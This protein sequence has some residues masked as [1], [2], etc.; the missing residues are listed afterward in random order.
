APPA[1]GTPAGGRDR[2]GRA[3][4]RHR[5]AGGGLAAGVARTPV[6]PARRSCDEEGRGELHPHSGRTQG[7]GRRLRERTPGPQPGDRALPLPQPVTLVP[8]PL[9][10]GRASPST[11]LTGPP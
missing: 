9:G 11:S 2:A 6:L 3:R 5:P 4:P 10:A 1:R 8:R 7:P